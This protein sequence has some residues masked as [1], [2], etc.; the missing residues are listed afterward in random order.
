MGNESYETTTKTNGEINLYKQ[1]YSNNNQ[2]NYKS[3]NIM[4]NKSYLDSSYNSFCGNI[5]NQDIISNKK[6]QK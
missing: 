6:K 1:S 3:K 5:S 2:N 4:N